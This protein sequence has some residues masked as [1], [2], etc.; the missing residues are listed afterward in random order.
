MGP[1]RFLQTDTY[2]CFDFVI[3]DWTQMEP[4][5]QPGMINKIYMS[6]K[7]E[8]EVHPRCFDRIDQREGLFWLLLVSIA[9]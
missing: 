5:Y 4:P 2:G 3:K 9:G 8:E 1:S 7:W 6:A